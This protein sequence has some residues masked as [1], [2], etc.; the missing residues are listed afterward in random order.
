VTIARLLN[1]NKTKYFRIVPVAV[2]VAVV[3]ASVAC[4]VAGAIVAS[5]APADDA[6]LFASVAVV[7]TVFA[8]AAVA[9]FVSAFSDVA[10]AYVIAVYI[11]DSDGVAAASSLLG[12]LVVVNGVVFLDPSLK[13]LLLPTMMT[14]LQLP[15]VGSC[16]R[17]YYCCLQY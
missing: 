11:V 2:D 10:V 3:L 5:T 13:S 17:S 12:V 9:A 1:V 8:H 14:H 7:E 4:A 6:F 16:C 15:P